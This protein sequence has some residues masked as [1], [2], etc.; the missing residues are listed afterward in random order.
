MNFTKENAVMQIDVGK[1]IIFITKKTL[2]ISYV[3]NNLRWSLI[4]MYI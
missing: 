4:K 3:K 2:F 1:E